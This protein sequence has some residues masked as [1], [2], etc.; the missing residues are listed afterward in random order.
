MAK[1][2]VPDYQQFPSEFLSDGDMYEIFMSNKLMMGRMISGSKSGYWQDHKENLVVFNANIIIESKGKIWHG[3]L[4]VTLDYEN[5]E[6]VAETLEE[7][8]Y[9]LGEHDARWGNEDAPTKELMEKAR[10]VIKHK[11]KDP[12]LFKD[13]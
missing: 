5:L 7:D 11:P 6:K 9:I 8:L 2:H 10:A 3:D 13:A 1:D 12:K 4:D